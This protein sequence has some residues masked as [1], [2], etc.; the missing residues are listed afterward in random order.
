MIPLIDVSL[1]LLVFFIMTATI[2]VA[3]L[4]VDVPPI[5]NPGLLVTDTYW[6]GIQ[7][8]PDGRASYSVGSDKTGNAGSE[9]T[10][11]QAIARLEALLNDVESAVDLRISANRGLANGLVMATAEKVELLKLKQKKLRNI[12]SEVREQSQ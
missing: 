12:Y 3:G 6:I 2:T 9:L 5:E 4:N 7:R 10:E 8:K 11:D 1:V